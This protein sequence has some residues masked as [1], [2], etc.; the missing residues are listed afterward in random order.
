MKSLSWWQYAMLAGAVFLLPFVVIPALSFP[1]Q[2]GKVLLFALP[3][4]AA[5]ILWCIH[6]LASGIITIP[7]SSILYGLFAVVLAYFISALAAPSTTQSLIGSG[8]E[9]DT[10]AFIFLLFLGV[11]ITSTVAQS[12]ARRIFLLKVTGIATLISALFVG[13]RLLFGAE[14]LSFGVFTNVTSNLLGKWNDLGLFFGISTLLAMVALYKREVI[15]KKRWIAWSV[16]GLSLIF[17]IIVNFSTAWL[18]L[19]IIS[20]GSFLYGLFG[21]RFKAGEENTKDIRI[22]ALIVLIVSTVFFFGGTV[23][24]PFIANA[25]GIATIEARPS[26][27]STIS[28]MGDVYRDNAFLGA[29]P[30]HFRNEWHTSKPAEVNQSFFWG[31]DFNAGV[32]TVATSAI[33]VGV[34]GILVWIFFFGAFARTGMRLLGRTI[35][36]KKEAYL[37][38]ATFVVSLY[39]WGVTLLYVPGIVLLAL[40]AIFT[41]LFIAS[42][43]SSNSIR[44]QTFSLRGNPRAGFISI[45]LLVILLILAA[46]VV[47]GLGSRYVSAYQQQRANVVLNQK[48]DTVGAASHL[49]FANAIVE[50][51]TAHRG[52]VN[53]GLVELNRI[54]STGEPTDETRAQFQQIL[55][56]TIGHGTRAIALDPNDYQNWLVLGQVY[57]A[58]VSINV[59]GAYEN[60][61]ETYDRAQVLNPTNPAIPLRIA[62]LELANGNTE[63]AL[64]RIS[65]ALTL[66]RNYTEAI[67]L[68]AQIQINAGNIPD[69]IRSVEA[70]TLLEPN[71][72]ALF[73][74]L[75]LLHYSENDFADAATA[76]E[77]AVNLNG[78]YSN[79]RY[80]L[81][82]AY[83]QLNRNSDAL[84]QFQRIAE[85]NPENTEVPA[86]IE[87]IKA[88]NEPFAG[89]TP[90]VPP[91]EREELPVEE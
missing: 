45:A 4:L 60:A 67:F 84:A 89:I 49:E 20:L 33:T 34:L 13:L 32:S 77:Q 16:F 88:G 44:K 66:K 25:L 7:R 40:T 36:N 75:G 68:L 14:F 69:A 83:H 78:D 31:T 29:G 79:A 46:V 23:F 80:F 15:G 52:L 2:F 59:E 48:G 3:V 38:T 53:L 35:E 43:M 17:L 82:L 50:T 28:V 8:S 18:L 64:S 51:D 76:F 37:L 61:R 12:S 55:E 71:N 24:G 1:F 74:Q 54:V 63:Q 39:L 57:E 70:T 65:D 91:E 19:G 9:T 87:N 5:F 22:P 26:W 72:P 21:S 41:G 6:A 81:G 58:L 56:T 47:Y 90:P 27:G 62:R 10:A 11:F 42:G 86:I 30:N 85:L 73:F